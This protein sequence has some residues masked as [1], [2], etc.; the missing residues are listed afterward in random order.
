MITK[1]LLTAGLVIACSAL[2]LRAAEITVAG[3][4]NAT[5]GRW[6]SKSKSKSLDADGDNVYGTAGYVVFATS[7]AG[8]KSGEV[9]VGDPLEAPGTLKSIPPFL[10]LAP[11]Q[12]NTGAQAA[13]SAFGYPEIDSP[14]KSSTQIQAGMA[15][16][17]QLEPTDMVVTSPV[18]EIKVGDGF[19]E[20]GVRVGVMATGFG[21]DKPETFILKQTNG[22]E[23]V[24]S[25]PAAVTKEFTIGY[26]FFDI[27]KATAGD[28][29]TVTIRKRLESEGDQP[30]A[31]YV[32]LTFDP[33]TK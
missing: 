31:S 32:G 9:T 7:P 20:G 18:A 12:V 1:R 33:I 30:T 19:P 8:S 11:A 10:T 4:D 5:G 24:E 17:V 21:S 3:T 14:E 6:R 25:A 23:A 16:V 27:K 29:F 28:V 22:G 15:A 2:Q 13:A 26:V